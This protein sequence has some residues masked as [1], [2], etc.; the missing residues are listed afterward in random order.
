[1]GRGVSLG[2]GGAVGLVAA[3]TVVIVSGAVNAVDTDMSISTT[4]I[5]FGQVNVGSPAQAR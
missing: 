1:M 4:A 5:D 3:A 2:I